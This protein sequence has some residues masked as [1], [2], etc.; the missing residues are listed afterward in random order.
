MR[1]HHTVNRN[2]NLLG[3]ADGEGARL[4]DAV[5]A[6][7]AWVYRQ[8]IR[9]QFTAVAQ[10]SHTVA[11]I[12]A[13]IDPHIEGPHLGRAADLQAA[14]AGHFVDPT[15]QWLVPV[16]AAFTEVHQAGVAQGR[17]LVGAAA[18]LAGRADHQPCLDETG[19][20]AMGHTA[21]QQQRAKGKQQD[22]GAVH[23]VASLC[24]VASLPGDRDFEQVAIQACAWYPGQFV[25]TGV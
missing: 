5:A 15:A 3:A 19:G 23:G 12:Q 4:A 18:D 8:L 1:H 14:F 20:G 22:R 10:A 17:G 25:D 7:A 11:A 21:G 2:R 13:A 24:M 6:V 9:D 16:R